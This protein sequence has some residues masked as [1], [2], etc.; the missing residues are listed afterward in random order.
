MY[1]I[2]LTGGLEEPSFIPFADWNAVL[3]S[4]HYNNIKEFVDADAGER[5]DILKIYPDA[6]FDTV[7]TFD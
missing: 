3:N 4:T 2:A 7:E 1:I 5:V 6:T